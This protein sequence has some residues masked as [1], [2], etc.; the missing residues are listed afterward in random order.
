MTSPRLYHVAIPGRVQSRAFRCL[1]L[2]EELDVD[3]FEVCMLTPGQ[4]YGAQMRAYGVPHST[5]LPTLQMDGKELTD[6]G[7]ISQIIAE[8][9]ASHTPLLGTSDER[10][11]LLQW[12]GFAETCIT[13]RIPLLPAL[14]NRDKS[15]T[16]LQAEAIDPMRAVFADNVARFEAHFEAQDSEYLL[17]SGFSIADTMCGWS[18]YTFHM[19]GIMDLANGTSPKTLAYLERLRG[20]PAFTSAEAYAHTAPGLYRRGCVP[21]D[22]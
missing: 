9:Y 2:L 6:S 17:P 7:V 18:L 4:P 5:K 19:W 11:D 3:D 12:V 16:E 15:L 10:V 21:M 22:T 8:K 1:W 20:R 13:F 14:M